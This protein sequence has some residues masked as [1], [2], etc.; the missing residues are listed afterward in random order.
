MLKS[1]GD[2]KEK[3]T[4]RPAAQARIARLNGGGS[5]QSGQTMPIDA[6]TFLNLLSVF[7]GELP[8]VR[9]SAHPKGRRI[10]PAA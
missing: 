3:V 6:S 10:L 8:A 7:L 2:S 4:A 5:S 1:G 9:L